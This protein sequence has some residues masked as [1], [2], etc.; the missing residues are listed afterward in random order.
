[1]QLLTRTVQSLRILIHVGRSPERL[2]TVQA[3]AEELA[4]PRHYATKLVYELVRAGF[5]TSIRGRLG[6]VAL[7]R[8]PSDIRV[9]EVV[10]AIEDLQVRSDDEQGDTTQVRAFFDQSF[11]KFV[12]VLNMQTIEDFYR[13]PAKRSSE[14]RQ[15]RGV[16]LRDQ[17]QR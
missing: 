11:E 16:Q 3:I 1:M 8:S 15:V 10:L 13:R 4:I 5:L 7:A 14:C 9:G 6:G 2:V 12:E 17:P